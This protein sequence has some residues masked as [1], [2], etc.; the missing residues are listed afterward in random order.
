MSSSAICNCS[1]DHQCTFG[2][3]PSFLVVG[4][5]VGWKNYCFSH[6]RSRLQTWYSVT[7]MLK[8][9]T[10]ENPAL[11]EDPKPVDLIAWWRLALCSRNVAIYIISDHIVRHTIILYYYYI[12]SIG[13]SNYL[14]SAVL[15]HL[16]GCKKKKGKSFFKFPE[17][18]STNNLQ[19]TTETKLCCHIQWAGGKFRVVIDILCQLWECK[20]TLSISCS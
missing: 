3:I 10:A 18:P 17:F 13:G 2:P 16:I 19:T 7:W 15:T 11:K 20:M 6:L 14:L 9:I 4:L 5:L 1:V 8:P 12:Y